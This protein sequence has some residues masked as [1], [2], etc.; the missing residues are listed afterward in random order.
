MEHELKTWPEEFKAI[1]DGTK[2]FELRKNDRNFNVGDI[3]ILKEYIPQSSRYT[4]KTCRRIVTYI[5]DFEEYAFDNTIL[6]K[7]DLYSYVIM[8]LN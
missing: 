5:L 1:L 2:P 4:G 8:G 7:E 6:Q 3:L